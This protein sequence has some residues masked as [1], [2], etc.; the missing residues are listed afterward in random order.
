MTVSKQN[1]EDQLGFKI[2]NNQFKKSY[3]RSL[4]KLNDIISRFGNNNGQ[5]N[6]SKYLEELIFEDIIA[7]AFSKSTILVSTNMLNME[8]EHSVKYQSALNE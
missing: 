3:E 5:R 2:T 7:D 4:K 1:V 8:K 6:N